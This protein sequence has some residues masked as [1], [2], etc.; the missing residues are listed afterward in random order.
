MKSAFSILA[1]LAVVVLAVTGA[2][3]AVAGTTVTTGPGDATDRTGQEATA[4]GATTWWD[5]D[6]EYRRSVEV[7]EQS[8]TNLHDYPVVT[9]AIDIG[10]ASPASIRVVDESS[11]EVLDFAVRDASDGYR[12]AFR[13]NVEAE[14][15]RSDLAIYYGNPDATSVAA[16]WNQVRYNFYDGFDDGTLH[17]NW[18][19]DSG[20]WTE[21]SGT[22]KPFGDAVGI[23]RNLSR[24][25]VQSDMPI[26]W[27]TR[28]TSRST[29]SSTDQRHAH[30]RDDEGNGHRMTFVRTLPNEDDGVGVD[31]GWDSPDRQKLL[32]AD[33]FSVGDP[34]YQTVLLRQD[35]DVQAFA[36]N[37]ANGATGQRT[38]NGYETYRY[39]QVI[40][41]DHG[42]NPGA[43]WD[44]VKIRY[45]VDPEP[46]VTVHDEQTRSSF[47]ETTT[48]TATSTTVSTTVTTETAATTTATTT[49][50][51]PTTTATPTTTTGTP[52]PE[53]TTTKATATT[54]AETTTALDS[55]GD[56]VPD[57]EDYAPDDPSVQS[58]SDVDDESGGITI[59]LPGFSATTGVVGIVLAALL[60]VRRRR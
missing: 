18:T 52:T 5:A 56:G 50:E 39:T 26:L 8:V 31:I 6:W 44:Y 19:V 59:R 30:L 21:S 29:G 36:E 42:G 49:T 3:V 4:A 17:P 13:V 28:V 33:Q 14:G 22:L 35:G 20:E 41:W 7:T 45:K 25:L 38:Y 34:I 53:T 43:E 10:S 54:T 24:P 37:E 2:T 15:T 16:E 1:T 60:L 32:Q 57:D 11:G 47:S 46:A 27:E 9:R 23:H 40:L 51:T 58:K 55:D 12:V 48:T